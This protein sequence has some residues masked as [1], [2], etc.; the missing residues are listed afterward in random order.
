MLTWHPTEALTLNAAARIASRNYASLDNSDIVGN[1]YQGFYRYF[2][3][4]LRAQYRL[5]DQVDLSLGV[6]NLTNDKYFL[7]HP[8]PQR[9]LIAE[10]QV[11]I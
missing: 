10:V 6:E 9:S 4:D 7:F 2:V 5:T 1:T 3:V 8:F 11:H